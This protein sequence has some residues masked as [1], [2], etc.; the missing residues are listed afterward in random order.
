MQKGTCDYKY[1]VTYE[2]AELGLIYSSQSDCKSRTRAL[3]QTVSM[4]KSVGAVRN[5]TT[6][7]L[8]ML[9]QGNVN[10]HI[11]Q[12]MEYTFVE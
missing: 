6:G 8:Q 10:L 9:K 11:F 2:Y 7:W 1:V 3:A 4:R 5:F 12:E